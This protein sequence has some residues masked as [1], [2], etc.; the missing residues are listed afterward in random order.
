MCQKKE[1]PLFSLALTCVLCGSSLKGKVGNL[2]SHNASVLWHLISKTLGFCIVKLPSFQKKKIFSPLFNLSNLQQNFFFL[3]KL[4]PQSCH[5]Y[6][7]IILNTIT[8]NENI[9]SWAA[10]FWQCE[11]KEVKWHLFYFIG[12]V[13][14]V[15][16][17]AGSDLAQGYQPKSFL[18]KTHLL[19]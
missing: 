13:L 12:P 5:T 3:F 16:W 17:V 6:L 4:I 14:S 7:A 1:K 11:A 10:A 15:G 19:L 18:G 8:T 9:T 2:F